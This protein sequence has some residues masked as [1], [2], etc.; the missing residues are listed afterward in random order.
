MAFSQKN[1]FFNLKVSKFDDDVDILLIEE[2]SGRESL[3]GLFEFHLR[4]QSIE[5]GI[6]PLDI[7]G[8]RAVLWIEADPASGTR[9]RH[10]NGY[11]SRFLCTGRMPSPDKSGEEL[12]TYECDIVPW[13]W[14]LTQHEDNRIFENLTVPEIVEQVVGKLGYKE[15]FEMDLRRQPPQ[16]R[17]CVQYR[18]TTFD[19]ISRLLEEEGIYYYFV[20]D[21]GDET[22]HRMVLTDHNDGNPSLDPASVPFHHE[23][24]SDDSGSIRTLVRD[25][26]MRTRK[27]T[28]A[29][30]DY[31]AKNR[32]YNEVPTTLSKLGEDHAQLERYRHASGYEGQGQDLTAAPSEVA[33]AIEEASHV[34]LKGESKVRALAP[35]YA[36]T[37]YDYPVHESFNRE[38]LVVSVEHHGRNNLSGQSESDYG[39]AFALIPRDLPYHPPQAAT[40]TRMHGPQTAIVVDD[41]DPEQMCR[42]RVQFHWARANGGGNS[43]I[44]CWLRVA[45]PWSGNGYGVMFLPRINDEV[46]VD[47]LEGDP[48]RPIVVG[49]VYNGKD[50]PPLTVSGAN[51]ASTIKTNNRA[52]DNY[53]EL[54]FDDGE[55]TEEIFLHSSRD[56]QIEVERDAITHIKGE[57]H[58]VVERPSFQVFND[59]ADCTYKKNTTTKVEGEL[60][61]DSV[62][63]IHLTSTA[64]IHQ[65]GTGGIRLTG[66]KGIDLKG[67][68]PI[69]IEST[70]NIT[71]KVGG[72]TISI[73][74]ATISIT[75]GM[76]LINSGGGGGSATA[77]D[78][79]D[80]AKTAK[81][82]ASGKAGKAADPVQQQQA[83]GLVAAAKTAAP[84]CAICEAARLVLQAGNALAGAT[85]DA[86]TDLAAGR[87]PGT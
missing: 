38:Y 12:F 24:A 63:A 15:H 84:F 86:V 44:S 78:K 25:E 65:H 14:M 81:L 27:T 20:H 22:T 68:G 45:Q 57:S 36:F 28:F 85:A 80:S 49:A 50:E 46:L 37:L 53:H 77:A 18:E 2:M 23:N 60:H 41:V 69:N 70:A 33:M 21:E 54:R 7:I 74:P 59:A 6:N 34:R 56:L 32:R 4:L 42:I 61:L 79:A 58:T 5:A 51:T 9:G 73:T 39:N 31:F 26:Q 52:G 47:F 11:V 13:F 17:Y 55:N 43:E 3:S 19:F 10:W 67:T 75:G 16:R 62:G 87:L 76:V 30:W 1:R 8:K 48:D 64:G 82:A 72:S 71:L 40:R 66:T 35:G 83:K 29:D